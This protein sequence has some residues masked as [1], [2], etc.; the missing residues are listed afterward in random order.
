M[1]RPISVRV[2][3]SWSKSKQI[4]ATSQPCGARCRVFPGVQGL[5]VDEAEDE[6]KEIVEFLKDPENWG[7]KMGFV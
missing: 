2:S 5:F 6:L 3:S 4:A 1:C 7:R